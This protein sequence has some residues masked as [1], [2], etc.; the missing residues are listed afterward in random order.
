MYVSDSK[1]IVDNQNIYNIT[2]KYL[3]NYYYETD[4]CIKKNITSSSLSTFN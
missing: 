3:Y 2:Y 1:L 4:M